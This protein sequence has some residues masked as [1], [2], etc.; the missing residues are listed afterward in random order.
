M[1]TAYDWTSLAIFAGLVVLFLQRSTEES[2]DGNYS[3]LL[4][5][6]PGVGCA[7]A[8]NLGNKGYDVV[9]ILI[10]VATVGFIFYFLKPFKFGSPPDK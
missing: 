6:V 10:I 2:P 3:L 7:A 5:L 4:Y 8:N 1:E 9:A